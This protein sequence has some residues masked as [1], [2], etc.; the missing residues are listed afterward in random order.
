MVATVTNTLPEFAWCV[1]FFESLLLKIFDAMS[2]ASCVFAYRRV[3]DYY[4]DQTVTAEQ[5]FLR[6]FMIHDFGYRGCG[7]EEAAQITG[8]AQLLLSSGSDTVPAREY[9]IRMYGA[10][11]DSV[12]MLSPPASEH[13]VACSYGTHPAGEVEYLRAMLETYPEGI[14]S[15]V[16]DTTNVYELVTTRAAAVK[17]LIL[18]R[19]GKSVFRPDSGNP[20]NVLCGDE[21]APASSKERAGVIRLLDGQFGHTRN[22]KGYRL[23]N[24]KIGLIYGDGMYLKRYAQTLERMRQMEYAASTLVIGVGGILRMHSRDTLGITLKDIYMVIDGVPT[25]IQ[26]DPI[27]DR[28][29]KSHCGLPALRRSDEGHLYTVDGCTDEEFAASLTELVYQDGQLYNEPKFADMRA[30]A[31]AGLKQYPLTKAE[32]EVLLA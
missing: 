23:L 15:L 4:F 9:A 3:V 29:K 27:T 2:T 28:S 24:E 25:N 16:S 26:K 11:R 18:S 19:P 32:L 21:G 8:V 31:A 14:V 5:D 13:A 20:P 10:E 22:S 1:G 7:T 12:I 30:R 6:D 17:D